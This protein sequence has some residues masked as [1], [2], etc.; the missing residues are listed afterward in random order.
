MSPIEK[1]IENE[2]EQRP[3]SIFSAENSERHWDG[4]E[5]RDQ[6]A[7]RQRAASVGKLALAASLNEYREKGKKN[8]RQNLEAVLKENNEEIAGLK[9]RQE[10]IAKMR[11]QLAKKSPEFQNAEKKIGRAL[12]HFDENERGLLLFALDR[13]LNPVRVEKA[14]GEGG[15]KDDENGAEQV[16]KKFDERG[17]G[18]NRDETHL[19]AYI[20]LK[21]SELRTAES[22]VW[23]LKDD[24]AAN[25]LNLRMA[26]KSFIELMQEKPALAADLFHMVKNPKRSDEMKLRDIDD[27]LSAIK[28]PQEAAIINGYLDAIRQNAS[29]HTLNRKI[30]DQEKAALHM[31]ESIE[32]A[33][34]K[35]EMDKALAQAEIPQEKQRA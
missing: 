16:L 27:R 34:Q 3:E 17:E 33:K 5:N 31:K 10:A 12:A 26:E 32:R 23:D 11:E 6:Y 24:A 19:A 29:A 21:E 28:N 9:G 35:R 2:S 14:N 22:Q 7:R 30:A 20:Y 1:Q 4:D 18:E 25:E 13:E 15:A 8:E